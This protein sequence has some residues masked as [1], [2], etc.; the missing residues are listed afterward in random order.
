MPRIPLYNQGVGPTQGLAAGQLSP[1]AN[2]TAFTAP[3]RA[4]AG[5]Q[6]TLS[7]AGKVAADFELAQQK[8]NADTLD[9][10]VKSIL[11]EEF[12]KL[13]RQELDDVSLYEEELGK[14]Q[15]TINTKIETTPRIN[16][17]LKSTVQNNFDT[18]FSALSV[19]GKQVTFERKRTN[20]ANSFI[21]G[22]NSNTENARKNPDLAE[23]LRS[24]SQF[25][26]Q[27]ARE[28]GVE[29]MLPITFQEYFSNFK[30]EQIAIG[31]INTQEKVQN[32]TLTLAQ[33]QENFNDVEKQIKESSRLNE[34]T[35]QKEQDL[36]ADLQS[37][38]QN[39]ETIF[40]DNSLEVVQF[41]FPNF[42]IGTVN[43]IQSGLQKGETEF[44][45]KD[46]Q[47]NDRQ[48]SFEGL[49]QASLNEIN[50]ELIK[51]T[52]AKRIL[53]RDNIIGFLG[54]M[55]KDGAP[56]EDFQQ[57]ADALRD[58]ED[59][60][61][62]KQDGSVISFNSSFLKQAVQQELSQ[63]TNNFLEDPEELS[64]ITIQEFGEKV[65]NSIN[66]K[67]DIENII[68]GRSDNMSQ[69]E[70]EEITAI[71]L[72]TL[73]Q[74]TVR[75]LQVTQD[76]NERAVLLDRLND[77]E[78]ILTSPLND[79]QP[80]EFR[81]DN[82]GKIANST[83][84]QISEIE[85]EI[86]KQNVEES[87]KETIKQTIEQGKT[88]S[89]KSIGVPQSE[90]DEVALQ[91]MFEKDD[92][93]NL[94][95]EEKTKLIVN[96]AED[97][98]T[99]YVRW[100]TLL[101]EGYK[102][103]INANLTPESEDFNSIIEGYNLYQFLK[104]YKT[105]LGNHAKPEQRVFYDE[106]ENRLPFEP[107]EKAILNTR[108]TLELKFPDDI[109]N[110]QLNDAMDNLQKD[111]D[112]GFL[113]FFGGEEPLNR[114]AAQ[115]ILKERAK[116]Y[117]QIGEART[118]KEALQKASE[119]I[120]LDYVF[121]EGHYQIKDDFNTNESL[122][123]ISIEETKKML[124][125][126]SSNKVREKVILDPLEQYEAKDLKIVKSEF[127]DKYI[128]TDDGGRPIDGIVLNEKGEDTLIRRLIT[129]TPEQMRE[130]GEKNIEEG[131][132]QKRKEI[133]QKQIDNLNKK[134]TPL[135]KDVQS[136]KKF[137]NESLLKKDFESFVKALQQAEE[138]AD[139]FRNK[140]G[141]VNE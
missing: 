8:I 86:F 109:A 117:L 49:S 70:S 22:L 10:E 41:N 18:R 1:R 127:F 45:V 97:T 120:L 95:A 61:Y 46:E 21:K 99:K 116:D 28:A 11:D 23:A 40:L 12:S 134:P 85:K 87:K 111:F 113:G 65:I 106:L 136:V 96:I 73:T 110:A 15:E 39:S 9:T 35:F 81:T 88:S 108:K 74:S 32:K 82:I 57:A 4:F 69:N 19:G 122:F 91:T 76:E 30:S 38:R 115:N 138:N 83:L 13:E 93:E 62:S 64:Q 118:G 98:G 53:E 77:I 37:V 103:G 133:Q 60:T 25:I 66:S 59:F 24:D 125:E 114:V 67:P 72:Q 90:I 92:D 71:T 31:L 112:K 50:D 5:F 101:G 94:S 132:I 135:G 84:N 14:I 129:I 34:I 44:V 48:I 58:G 42:D 17:R 27:N 139:K 7:Q 89:L 102:N 6:Q 2:T 121:V 105:V 68:L 33:A 63:F 126:E 43:T 36:L 80:F 79:Q 26:F 119:D 56:N 75:K 137:Y 141:I 47:G 100:S 16:S 3:G 107:I 52:S 128:I 123:K 124:L 130:L 131:L 55:Q 51:L 104:N 20:L 78:Q 29:T 140:K 54:E